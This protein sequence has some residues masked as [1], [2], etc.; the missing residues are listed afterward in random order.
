MKEAVKFISGKLKQSELNLTDWS[1]EFVNDKKNKEKYFVFERKSRG[2]E[3]K[4]KLTKSILNS[5]E[6]EI[7]GDKDIRLNFFEIVVLFK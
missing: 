7:L 6:A 2:I 5:P 1:G 3:E 4:Y